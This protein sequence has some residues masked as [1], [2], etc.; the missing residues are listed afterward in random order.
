MPKYLVLSG[1]ILA[2]AAATLV[3][4]NGQNEPMGL[5]ASTS[6]ESATADA[7]GIASS[8]AL[9]GGPQ[10]G[11]QPAYPVHQSLEAYQ[12]F[13]DSDV[14]RVAE[15][16]V[17]TFAIDV[18]SGSYANIRRFLMNGQKPP[19]HAV[20]VEEMLNYFTY[21][22]RGPTDSAQPFLA[23]SDIMTTP[24]NANTMLLR[25]G[26][27][28]YA[29]VMDDRPPANLVFLIDVSGSM[30][31]TDKLP[32]LKSSMKLLVDELGDD[33]KITIVTYAGNAGLVL[34]PT[35]AGEKARIKT[36]I[37]GLDA[38]GST[39][40]GEGIQ[41]AY[42]KAREALIEGG[43]NRIL[44]AT[45]GDFN[46]GVTDIGQLKEMIEEA[47]KSGIALSTLGFG[48]GN[49]NDALME[50]I[51]DIGNGNY[52]YVDSLKEA[53]RLLVDSLGGTMMTIA[54]DVKIQIEFNP[55]VIAEY[56]LI[57]YENR[58]LNREDF[59]NDAKD[60]GEIGAGHTVTALYEIALVG[61]KGLSV[62]PLR[63]QVEPDQTGEGEPIRA[64]EFALLRLRYKAPDGDVSKLIETPLP[65]AW[66]KQE[67]DP[68]ADDK[69]A[70]AVA[71]FGQYLRGGERLG[72]F[73]LDQIA[74]LARA[75]RGADEDGYRAEF[76][77]LVEL[78]DG[79]SR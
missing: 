10:I 42:A 33:D 6:Q 12:A 52:G 72:Q 44:L 30:Q 75:G 8:S 62:D 48:E 58:A 65:S 4:C 41:L 11:L 51:A 19:Q 24:W 47:R 45:D 68:S 79:V 1:S 20:R 57:G 64:E 56:R 60:A 37:D 66:L 16:P 63:Y 32:L 77:D 13:E 71:A 59:N 55:A 17:S 28:G 53:K 18:D 14:K 73:D 9:A 21:D 69:F 25:V 35:S 36:A 46:V 23:S 27:K 2:L 54:K 67:R 70:A 7:G 78:A 26:I 29:P 15:A 40:G 22:Y 49:Y 74:A 31:D 34:A 43:I 39:A 76:I 61:S 38:G 50:Q 5:T 3:A